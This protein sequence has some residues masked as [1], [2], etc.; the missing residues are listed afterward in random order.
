MPVLEFKTKWASEEQIAR[1][2][3]SK[4]DF[5]LTNSESKSLRGLSHLIDPIFI[6][7]IDFLLK[8]TAERDNA[9][10]AVLLAEFSLKAN[11]ERLAALDMAQPTRSATYQVSSK[12]AAPTSTKKALAYSDFIDEDTDDRGDNQEPISRKT[13]AKRKAAGAYKALELDE[14][15]EEELPTTRADTYASKRKAPAKLPPTRM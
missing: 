5:S 14:D 10:V 6:P 2:E 15:D 1:K 3:L 11:Q 9:R 12:P 8:F 13:A 4:A 7:F